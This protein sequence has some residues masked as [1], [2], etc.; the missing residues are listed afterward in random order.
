LSIPTFGTGAFLEFPSIQ[1]NGGCVVIGDIAP[2]A[3]LARHWVPPL[4]AVAGFL[5]GVTSYMMT[6]G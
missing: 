3:K 2:Q 1:Q 5:L 6:G 4:G